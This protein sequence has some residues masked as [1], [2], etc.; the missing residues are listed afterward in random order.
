M[1]RWT[2][3]SILLLAAGTGCTVCQ[4]VQRTVFIEPGLF[5]WKTDAQRSRDLYFSWAQQAWR[6]A[7]IADVSAAYE[8]GFREGF[9]EFVFGGG[10]GE[11]PVVPPRKFWN[12]GW[13]SEGGLSADDWLSLSRAK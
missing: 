6:E 4:N 10:T 8:W 1:L 5:D 9:A 7:G 13:R 3:S 11:P 2:F 12:L